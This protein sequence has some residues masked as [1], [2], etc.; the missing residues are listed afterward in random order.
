[1]SAVV[2]LFE[3]CDA[4]KFTYELITSLPRVRAVSVMR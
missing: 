1:M 3:E 4:G 2:Q